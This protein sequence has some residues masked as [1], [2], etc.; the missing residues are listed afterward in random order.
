[1]NDIGDKKVE[2]VHNFKYHSCN[3]ES[4]YSNVLDVKQIF[5]FCVV[6]S[7]EHCLGKLE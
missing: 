6:P 2:H 1:M 4:Q 5:N 7:T 3:I